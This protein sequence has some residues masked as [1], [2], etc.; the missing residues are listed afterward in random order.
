MQATVVKTKDGTITVRARRGYRAEQLHSYY[1]DLK[2]GDKIE[3][4]RQPNNP[5][6]VR[7]ARSH[8]W[9]K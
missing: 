7:I 6:L 8:S 1:A 4:I 2:V 9:Q 3:V 5:Y